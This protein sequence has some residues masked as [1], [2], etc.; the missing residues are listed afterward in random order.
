LTEGL[1]W[2]VRLDRPRGE[3]LALTVES[4]AAAVA[5][6]SPTVVG[7]SEVSRFGIAV[8]DDPTKSRVRHAGHVNAVLAHGDGDVLVGADT[9]GVWSGNCPPGRGPSWCRL[10]R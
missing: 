2:C 9:G 3:P 5:N 10:S 6:V 7:W 8:A 4:A 1:C